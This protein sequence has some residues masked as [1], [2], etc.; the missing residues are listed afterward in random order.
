VSGRGVLLQIS[1][2]PM[3]APQTPSACDSPKCCVDA[4][5]HAYYDFV[6]RVQSS[7]SSPAAWFC[8]PLRRRQM[9]RSIDRPL[10][11]PTA[12]LGNPPEDTKA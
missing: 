12:T 9:H 8:C 10:T 2:T 7:Q 5:I 1:L 11:I 6:Q 4:I 3:R